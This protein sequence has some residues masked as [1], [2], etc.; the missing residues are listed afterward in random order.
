MD[1]PSLLRS[2]GGTGGGATDSLGR[3]EVSP[4]KMAPPIL[5]GVIIV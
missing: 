2:F 5:S 4:W 1:P 3:G